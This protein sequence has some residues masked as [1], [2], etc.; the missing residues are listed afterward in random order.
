MRVNLVEREAPNAT[1]AYDPYYCFYYVADVNTVSAPLPW[2]RLHE[3]NRIYFNDHA[4]MTFDLICNDAGIIS[5]IAFRQPIIPG[6]WYPEFDHLLPVPEKTLLAAVTDPAIE[7]Y[8]IESIRTT[9]LTSP[10]YGNAILVLL[11]AL[12]PTHWHPISRSAFIGIDGEN[13]A[14]AFLFFDIQWSPIE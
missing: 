7:E 12:S 6:Q 3:N 11:D 1:S 8:D 13:N 10:K 9:L 5:S 14:T 2:L 4:G